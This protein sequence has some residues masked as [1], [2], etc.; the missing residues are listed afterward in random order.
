MQ[1]PDL[2]L[3]Q[4]SQQLNTI[5]LRTE[6]ARTKETLGKVGFVWSLTL[7]G[8]PDRQY[9]VLSLR[10]TKIVLRC[11]NGCRCNSKEGTTCTNGRMTLQRC[12]SSEVLCGAPFVLHPRGCA[13]QDAARL[14][15]L[16][17]RVPGLEAD[18]Q[19]LQEQLQVTHATA[20]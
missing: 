8:C 11:G 5:D 15:E 6:L 19:A 13:T 3:A 2:E 9:F 12:S 7:G 17:D 18:C 14:K 10:A 4:H 20:S 16:A 1:R